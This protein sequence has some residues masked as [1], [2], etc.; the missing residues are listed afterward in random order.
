MRPVQDCRPPAVQVPGD[1]A[2]M[3]AHE[4]SAP[5]RVRIPAGETSKL[6]R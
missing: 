4:H 5:G 3:A 6:G 1:L 2:G